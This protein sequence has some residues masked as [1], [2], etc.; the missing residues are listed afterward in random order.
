MGCFHPS[1][2]N[3][4]SRERQRQIVWKDLLSNDHP[5]INSMSNSTKW[6]FLNP[7]SRNQAVNQFRSFIS[8]HLVDHLN[9]HYR[10]ISFVWLF[11]WFEIIFWIRA[12]SCFVSEFRDHRLQW[13]LIHEIMLSCSLKIV[14][15][16][17]HR[18]MKRWKRKLPNGWYQ[19]LRGQ[20]FDLFYF[21]CFPFHSRNC[22]VFSIFTVALVWE[23]LET[24][25]GCFPF[26][27]MNNSC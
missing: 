24:F 25:S 27:I 6:S 9:S 23:S 8:I 3:M 18:G 19:P 20:P 10:L 4:N 21:F 26:L 7:D 16:E 1:C 17:L 11:C 22:R 13:R 15:V 14:S 5:S 2:S 12:E